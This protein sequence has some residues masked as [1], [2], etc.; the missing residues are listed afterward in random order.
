MA[1]FRAIPGR[2]VLAA[3]TVLA[4]TLTVCAEE[5]TDLP[6][7]P[8]SVAPEQTCP[9]AAEEPPA[10]ADRTMTASWNNGF[11]ARTNDDSFRIHIGGRMDFD[12]SWFAQ[13]SNLLLGSNVGDTLH[14][15]ALFRRARLRADGLL[16]GW[17]DFA[18][19]VNFAN[20][21]DASN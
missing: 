20:I 2:C 10:A 12:N 11:V 6:P 4:G 1:T 16:W 3:L 17:I 9:A 19:E 7:A 15:E 18:A 8:D 21:Q 13:D 14:D 5:P